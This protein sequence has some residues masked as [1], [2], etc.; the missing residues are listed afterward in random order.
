MGWVLY[1][2]PLG[3]PRRPVTVAE[4]LRMLDT[5]G[6]DYWNSPADNG[7]A[8]LDYHQAEGR[9][10]VATLIWTAAPGCGFQFEHQMAGRAAA[11]YAVSGTDF[12]DLVTVHRSGEPARLPRSLFIGPKLAHLVVTEFMAT[13]GRAAGVRWV[14][15]D[16]IPWA[17]FEEE[18]FPAEAASTRR[19]V[20]QAVDAARQRADAIRTASRRTTQ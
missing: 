17:E 14:S 16:D 2:D 3:N 1:S 12:A 9:P 20:R 8:V 6:P 19:Q 15:S 11:D 5:M 13:G 7:C 18:S 4:V 10:L